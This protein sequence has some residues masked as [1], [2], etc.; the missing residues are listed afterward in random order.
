MK[1][2]IVTMAL[3]LLS[4]VASAQSTRLLDATLAGKAAEVRELIQA[5][6]PVSQARAD[7]S[8]PIHAA[9]FKGNLDILQLLLD[10]GA[11]VNARSQSG[12]WPLYL[13]VIGGHADAVKWLLARG[14]DVSLKLPHGETAMFPAASA[15]HLD[16]LTLLVAA[17]ADIRAANNSGVTLAHAAITG[18]LPAVEWAIKA[19]LD[20]NLH[21]TDYGATPLHWAAFNKKD[22]IGLALIKAGADVHA[23]DKYGATPLHTAAMANDLTLAQAL[24]AS[25][26]DVNAKTNDGATPL[27]F[28]ERKQA[29]EVETFLSSVGN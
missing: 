13:A 14:A 12:V 7:G 22:D 21:E 1:A 18:N 16:I 27:D 19:G 23:V 15:G 29:V 6:E 2:L 17:G 4:G 10:K 8:Q 20:L 9:A 26:A 25:G 3:A 24:V 28:A 5:G 11:D